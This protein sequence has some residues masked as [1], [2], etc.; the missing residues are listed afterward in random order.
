MV[1][2]VGRY[3]C[4]YAPK[5]GG[6]LVSKKLS[7]SII[8]AQHS[9]VH[10]GDSVGRAAS[11]GGGRRVVEIGS[12]LNLEL[13]ETYPPRVYYYVPPHRFKVLFKIPS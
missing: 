2:Y 11:F 5:V 3:V 4:M 6:G 12:A 10:V 1:M 9:T 13:T 8:I 7:C